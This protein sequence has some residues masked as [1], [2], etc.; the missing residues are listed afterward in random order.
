MDRR[1]KDIQSLIE[2]FDNKHNNEGI[3]SIFPELINQLNLNSFYLW[4]HSF[5]GGTVSTLST[6]DTR[7]HKIVCLGSAFMH[8]LF[9]LI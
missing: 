7:I 8:V 1:V 6:I 4:G 5:G 9:D 3:Q 2:F